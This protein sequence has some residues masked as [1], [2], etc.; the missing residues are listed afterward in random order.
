MKKLLILT[1]AVVLSLG[2]AVTSEAAIVPLPVDGVAYATTG[3]AS[4]GGTLLDSVI[5]NSY[6]T[7]TGLAT[8]TYSAWVRRDT[9]GFLVFEYQIHN[10]PA[11]VT[12]IH[13]MTAINFTGFGTTSADAD[14]SGGLQASFIDRSFDGSTIGFAFSGNGIM[15]NMTSSI[16]WVKTD[17]TNYTQGWLQVINGGSSPNRPSFQPA[18]VPEPTSMLLFGTGLLGFV[19][20]LRKRFDV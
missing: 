5:G 14:S 10:S 8:G 1:L 15:P 11:S 16:M 4:P 2:L 6:T 19:G 3:D 7:G 18:P 13:R 12:G 17:A 20:R 9:D